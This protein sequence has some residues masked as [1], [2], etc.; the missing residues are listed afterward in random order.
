MNKEELKSTVQKSTMS[1]EELKSVCSLSL[2]EDSLTVSASNTEQLR[3][4]MQ[5]HDNS[6]LK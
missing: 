3:E 2:S 6:L 1:K 4:E 5:N